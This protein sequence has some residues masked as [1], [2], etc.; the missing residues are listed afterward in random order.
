VPA[1][2]V[3]AAAACGRIGFDPFRDSDPLHD[4][5]TDAAPDASAAACTSFSPWVTPRELTELHDSIDRGGSDWEY[6]AQIMPD[7]LTI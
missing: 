6:G 4:A 1:A 7:G 3:V 2:A 5:A